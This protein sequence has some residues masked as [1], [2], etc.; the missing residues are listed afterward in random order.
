MC[1]LF[2]PIKGIPGSLHF[3]VQG[4]NSEDQQSQCNAASGCGETLVLAPQ[5]KNR[6][7]CGAPKSRGDLTYQSEGI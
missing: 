4:L 7:V 6:L 2:V 1:L 3:R 5:A